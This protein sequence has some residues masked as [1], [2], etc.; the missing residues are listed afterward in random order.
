MGRAQGS[1]A[2]AGASDSGWLLSTIILPGVRD[3]KR[4]LKWEGDMNATTSERC[5]DPLP[6]G[7]HASVTSC[8][9]Y[10]DWCAII[11]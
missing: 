1:G 3:C 6:A 2:W 10:A 7:A 4:K 11:S 9:Q 5:G 8:K